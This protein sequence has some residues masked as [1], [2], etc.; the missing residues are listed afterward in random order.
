MY[1]ILIIDDEPVVREGIAATIDWPSH[2][3]DLVG[4]C[5]DGREG[6]AA[7]ERDQPDV[8]ITDICMPFVDGLE[9]AAWIAHR[10]PQIRTILL[11]GYD[12]FEYAQEA[13]RLQVSDFLLKPITADELRGMLDT[14]RAELDRDRESRE[15]IE[16]LHAQLAESLPLLRERFLNRLLHGRLG[17]EDIERKR[18]LLEIDLETGSYVVVVCDLDTHDPGQELAA[19]AVQAEIR[20]V[21]GSRTVGVAGDRDETVIIVSAE[22]EER[23]RSRALDY[24]ER[25]STAILTSLERSVSI[26]IGNAVSTLDAISRSYAEAVTALERRLQFGP[27]RI[28]T[29]EEVRGGVA[30]ISTQRENAYR[31][32]FVMAIRGGDSKSAARALEGFFS[33]FRGEAIDRNSCFVAVQRLLSDTL[34]ALDALGLDYRDVSLLTDN[35]FKRLA[36]IKTLESIASWFGDLEAEARQRLELRRDEHSRRK[37]IEAEEYIK[38]RFTKPDLTLTAVCTDLAVSKSYLSPI[39]KA[40]TGMTFVEFLTAVRIDY[41]KEL[42][43]G[44]DL[45]AYEIATKVGFRDA[46]YFSVTFRKQ[47]G[48]SPMEYRDSVVGSAR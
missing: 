33:R 35:P 26:G 6:I 31:E 3:F 16:Q 12:D 5:E 19:L 37:A 1:R 23:A 46:H 39:F 13:V 7:L 43:A 36:S 22:D 38:S 48:Q 9:L 18:K 10:Y 8:V 17:E 30:A 14:V 32:A 42:L 25:I 28:I 11:T 40:H 20:R 2:G 15:Q 41:A 24:S 47:T 34:D 21:L 45:K 27:G 29:V 4:I 44:G